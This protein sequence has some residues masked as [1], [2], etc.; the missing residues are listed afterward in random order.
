[1]KLDRGKRG[2]DGRKRVIK[3]QSW[4]N[5]LWKDSEILKKRIK[6]EA[7]IRKSWV[8]KCVRLKWG[9]KTR[10]E[11]RKVRKW[12][13]RLMHTREVRRHCRAHSNPEL[14]V[15]VTHQPQQ[16]IHHPVY[17]PITG[18]LYHW[19][20]PFT[21][22]S[23]CHPDGTLQHYAFVWGRKE[24]TVTKI[25]FTTCEKAAGSIPVFKY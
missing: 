3:Q 17:S 14:T 25:S 24:E 16:R 9:W 5:H 7:K 20:R 11:D 6:M 19:G 8:R 1:M 10:R 12:N 13:D 22:T 18:T 21:Y 23:R 15:K 2:R 4:Q